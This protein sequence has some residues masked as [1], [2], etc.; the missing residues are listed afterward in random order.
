MPRET[1]GR[2]RPLLVAKIGGSLHASPNLS[3][4]IEALTLWPHRLTLV[5]G[6]GPF[7]DAVRD[8]QPR[9]GYSDETAH[10]MAV[11]AME[12]YALALS[13]LHDLDLAATRGELDAAHARGRIALWR[14][15]TMVSCATDIAPGWDVTSDSLSAW[16]ARKTGADA[17]LL[18]K[19]VDVGADS[20]LESLASA[21]VVDPA[22][23]N[24]VGGTP[25]FV[26]GPRALAGAAQIIASGAVPGAPVASQTQKI[27]S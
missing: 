4:W 19:S 3:R 18:I 8:A 13:Q 15:S 5:S 12:Q 26:A 21:G 25:V 1:P 16:L 17:L 7:A 14:A 6:G 2:V 20:A 11:L 22:F 9:L 10:A 24:H 23:P 27:A